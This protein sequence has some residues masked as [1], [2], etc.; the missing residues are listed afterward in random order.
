MSP[1]FIPLKSEPFSEEAFY[2]LGE[3]PRFIRLLRRFFASPKPTQ[4]ACPRIQTG[5]GEMRNL[6]PT[7]FGGRQASGAS[8]P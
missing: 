3:T 5:A 4:S 2:A 1:L 7:H 8:K 6:W